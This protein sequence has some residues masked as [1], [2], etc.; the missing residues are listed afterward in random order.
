M[1]RNLLLLQQIILQSLS[2]IKDERTVNSIYHL[3]T[4]KQSIQT[5]QDAHLFH[6]EVF[7]SLYKSL[8]LSEFNEQLSILINQNYIQQSDSNRYELTVRG[9]AFLEA[10]NIENYYWNGMAYRQVDDEFSKRLLLMIQVWTNRQAKINKYIPI[11]DDWSTTNW[12]KQFYRQ[13]GRKVT[14]LLQQ[15]YESLVVIF[16]KLDPIYPQIFIKQITTAS[17]IG[18][19]YE[20]LAE[21]FQQ[22]PTTI[23]LL[24][25]NY[26]HFMLKIVRESEGEH[27]LLKKMIVD[28]N[29]QEQTHTVTT[30]AQATKRL[31]ENGLTLEEIAFKR[32]LKMTTIYDHIVEIALYDKGFPIDRFI[33]P[34]EKSVIYN[35]VKENQ[36]FKLKAIKERVGDDISYFQIRLALTQ[37][38]RLSNDEVNDD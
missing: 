27:E 33:S 21:H 24:E 13:E 36:S 2:K 1:R 20:Q 30:S 19:T 28:L 14:A 8:R 18:L 9:K 15:V 31:V 34:E 16:S 29:E 12:A 25:K 17:S 35:I 38:E 32:Q 3:L 7:F 4:G 37:V 5:I 11:I 10:S 23:F 22:S 6:L 26:I